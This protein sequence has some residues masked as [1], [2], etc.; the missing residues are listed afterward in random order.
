MTSGV[1]LVPSDSATWVQPRPEFDGFVRTSH[2]VPMKD[3]VR[4]A[5]DL[6]LPTPLPSGVRLPAVLVLT[7]YNRALDV[8]PDVPELAAAAYDS[9]MWGP[10][11]SVHGFAV[12]V[13]E[14]RGAAAS[15]GRRVVDPAAARDDVDVVEWVLLQPWSNGRVGAT[16]ISAPGMAALHLATAGHPAV[17]AVAPLW[18]A[19][20][21]FASTHPG[22]STISTFVS[23]I[24]D[25][26]RA[27]D[28]NR[29]ES[30]IP[31]QAA[32]LRPALRGLRRVDEDHDGSL[33]A[34]AIADHA[35]N[36]YIDRDIVAVTYRDEELPQAPGV[37]LDVTGPA[38]RFADLVASGTPVL[39][40]AGWYDGAFCSD[41]LTL[42]RSLPR[43]A[44]RL[45]VGPWGHGGHFHDSPMTPPGTRSGFDH[46]AE[47]AAFFR[48]HLVPGEDAAPVGPAVRYY[49]MGAQEGW[50][51]AESWPPPSRDVALHLGA[52]GSLAE[53]A[54][55]SGH[56][57][58]DVDVSV[59]AGPLSRFG[60]SVVP[61]DYG[62]RV[63]ADARLLAYQTEPLDAA[64]EV[65]G[66]PLLELYVEADRDDYLLVPYL[67]DVAPDGTVRVVTDGVLRGLF[68][69]TQPPPDGIV[70][71]GPYRAC[72][73]ADARPVVPGE[74][75]K[76]E[77]SLFPVSWV[78]GAGHAL[79]LTIAGADADNFPRV[80]ASGDVRLTVHRGGSTPSRLVL[81]VVEAEAGP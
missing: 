32:H 11:L 15:F 52:E 4:L 36:R 47:L 23:E 37:S 26:M 33:L 68:R 3:G 14:A 74:V 79:R 66:T 31:E 71:D 64:L 69:E 62:D 77:L 54:G 42:H 73:R 67:E 13:V 22:G 56:D 12:L 10:G 58:H 76:L 55:D 80:P 5:A 9:G 53:P 27:I 75:H 81:P 49:V 17:G 16:G 8:D 44:H 34:A 30:L 65:T 18:T 38:H 51:Q 21:M 1:G 24:G 43:G 60:R 46:A 20:D 25:G 39:T 19:F 50:R 29:L 59:G 6:Y 7:P 45:V 63:T 2:Y 35:D 61:V 28:E 40:Y 72:R 57:A 48:R 78:F 70:V 41:M